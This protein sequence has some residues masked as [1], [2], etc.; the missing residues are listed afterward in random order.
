MKFDWYYLQNS[1][2]YHMGGHTFNFLCF[3]FQFFDMYEKL[4]TSANYVTR[5]QSLKV[6][7]TIIMLFLLLWFL[8]ENLISNIYTSG[9]VSFTF[10]ASFWISFGGSKFWYNEALHSGSSAPESHDDIAE[11]I[12]WCLLL[13]LPLFLLCL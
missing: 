4:L 10:A 12:G 3:L 11:G 13:L 9:G 5:R 7:W 2:F 6:C 8:Q 1:W